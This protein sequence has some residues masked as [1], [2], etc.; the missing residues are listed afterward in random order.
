MNTSRTFARPSTARVD[1]DH[2]DSNGRTLDRALLVSEYV[3]SLEWSNWTQPTRV[4]GVECC[5][6]ESCD[7]VGLRRIVSPR[8]RVVVSDFQMAVEDISAVK[9]VLAVALN[10]RCPWKAAVVTV[11]L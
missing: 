3:R 2:S 11:E 1:W 9:D 4:Y 8:W 7:M 5:G 6:G 10:A